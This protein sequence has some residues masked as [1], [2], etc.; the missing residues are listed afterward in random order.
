VSGAGGSG[1]D[2]L[3]VPRLSRT[4][5]DLMDVDTVMTRMTNVLIETSCAYKDQV[6]V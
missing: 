5:L 1:L 6:S 2:K 3:L 4:M